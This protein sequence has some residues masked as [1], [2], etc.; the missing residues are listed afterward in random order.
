MQAERKVVRNKEQGKVMTHRRQEREIGRKM[1]EKWMEKEMKGKKIRIEG[2]PK[3]DSE[4][5]TY[6]Y[7]TKTLPF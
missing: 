3:H 6:A 2:T 5:C 7:G 1:I 4:Y